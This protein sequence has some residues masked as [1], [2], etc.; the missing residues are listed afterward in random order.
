[1]DV[2]TP[3]EFFEKI[4]P[5]K[6]DPN[7]AAGIDAIVQLNISKKESLYLIAS[8]VVKSQSRIAVSIMTVK[9]YAENRIN[10]YVIFM[11]C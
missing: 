7:K 6:F 11:G 4:L 1:M 9:N 8:M 2:K 10:N 5:A 3:K